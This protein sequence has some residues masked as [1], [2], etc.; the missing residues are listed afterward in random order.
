MSLSPRT[1][2]TSP[3]HD[4]Q[5]LPC[6]VNTGIPLDSSSDFVVSRNVTVFPTPPLSRCGVV[7]RRMIMSFT[8]S[9]G[10]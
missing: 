7:G 8:Y 6:L 1:E 10:V 5:W 4:R 2:L 3:R 9:H